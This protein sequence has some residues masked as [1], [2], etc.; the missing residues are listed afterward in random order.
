MNSEKQWHQSNSIQ[1]L[2]GRC[3]AGATRAELP[4]AA[5]HKADQAESEVHDDIVHS[6]L[7]WR[8]RPWCSVRP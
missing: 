2:R 3:L 6:G 8:L 5:C 7:L 1:A 4:P